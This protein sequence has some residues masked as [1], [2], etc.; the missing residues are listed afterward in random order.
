MWPSGSGK[1][2]LMNFIECLDAPTR[3]TYLLN[4]TNVDG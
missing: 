3:G 4:K 2:T 1:S